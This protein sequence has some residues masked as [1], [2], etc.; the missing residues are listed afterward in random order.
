METNEHYYV[1]NPYDGHP[2]KITN[3]EGYNYFFIGNGHIEVAVQYNKS[4]KGSPYGLIL[5][6]PTK[7]GKKSQSFT[8][9]E[10]TRV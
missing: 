7:F 3:G 5:M 9:D 8:F 2:D 4:Y 10:K 1:F 6:D